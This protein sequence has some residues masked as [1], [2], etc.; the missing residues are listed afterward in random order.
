MITAK[1]LAD[2]IHLSRDEVIALE[3]GLQFPTADMIERLEEALSIKL[4]PL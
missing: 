2:R 1:Q 3:K 4:S